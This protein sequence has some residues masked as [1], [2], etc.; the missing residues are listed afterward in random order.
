MA[1]NSAPKSTNKPA[2]DKKAKISHKTEWTG[3]RDT[4]VKMPPINVDIENA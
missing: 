4:T 1:T 3:L 2:A